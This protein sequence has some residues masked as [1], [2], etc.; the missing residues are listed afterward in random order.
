MRRH[1]A[2]CTTPLWK[3]ATPRTNV[4]PRRSRP[5]PL[6]MLRVGSTTC[7]GI[8]STAMLGGECRPLHLDGIGAARNTPDGSRLLTRPLVSRRARAPS[9]SRQGTTLRSRAQQLPASLLARAHMMAG[10]LSHTSIGWLRHGP[11]P[12]HTAR[13]TPGLTKRACAHR[14]RRLGRSRLLLH[15]RLLHRRPG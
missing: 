4:T 15:H 10:Q 9:A 2:A 3:W 5:L 7:P 6:P 12:P 8:G 14:L 13:P 1:G 11:A